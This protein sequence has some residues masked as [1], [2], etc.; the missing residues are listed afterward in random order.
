MTG[1]IN[2]LKDIFMINPEKNYVG[3]SGIKEN[4]KKVKKTIVKSVK[5]SEPK[6]S[7]LMRKSHTETR[8]ETLNY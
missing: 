5:K 7:E 4:K 1:F 2:F 6:L 3:L 8:E